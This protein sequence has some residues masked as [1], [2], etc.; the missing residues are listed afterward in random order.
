M[1]WKG[2]KYFKFNCKIKNQKK[3]KTLHCSL[4][5]KMLNSQCTRKLSSNKT[6]AYILC[7]TQSNRAPLG[8]GRAGDTHDGYAAYK[9][10]SESLLSL[11][12]QHIEQ[13]TKE[14]QCHS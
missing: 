10:E 13:R 7:S 1:P 11:Q 6:I 12:Q 8:C 14:K 5:I 3:E 4:L 9:S 2:S